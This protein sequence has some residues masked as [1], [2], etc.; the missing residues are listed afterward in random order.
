MNIIDIVLDSMGHPNHERFVEVER[1]DTH[2]SINLSFT[3]A[4]LEEA[5]FRRVHIGLADIIANAPVVPSYEELPESGI[6]AFVRTDGTLANIILYDKL[7]SNKLYKWMFK[8]HKTTA[9]H[10]VVHLLHVGDL[11]LPQPAGD[12]STEEQA[13]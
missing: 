13:R 10:D 11:A 2:D 4:L 7:G 3:P 1:S 12:A 6:V 9:D 5:H 8:H